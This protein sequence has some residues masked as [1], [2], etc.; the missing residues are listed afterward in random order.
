MLLHVIPRWCL[1]GLDPVQNGAPDAWGLGQAIT[2]NMQQQQQQQQQQQMQTR[3]GSASSYILNRTVRHPKVASRA[4]RPHHTSMPI[5]AVSLQ[6][7]GTGKEA[8]PGCTRQLAK[9]APRLVHRALP[10]TSKPNVLQ[11]GTH[12]LALATSVASGAT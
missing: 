4:R 7:G 8:E 12:W 11:D 1:C 3:V 5:Q 10:A 6:H 2:P 9:I